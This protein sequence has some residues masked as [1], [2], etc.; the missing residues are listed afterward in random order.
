MNPRITAAD[1]RLHIDG[2]GPR[3]LLFLH[4]W[5]DTHRLWDG[6]VDA[7]RDRFRCARFT[8]PGF[9][10]GSAR[11]LPDL[12]DITALLLEVVDGLS[13]GEPVTLVLHDWGC[14]FGYQFALRHPQRV[15]RI[16][17]V[18]IG[19]T[20]NLARQLTGREKLGVLGYQLWLAA[21][22]RVGGGAGDWMTRRVARWAGA[23]APAS[24]LGWAMNWPYY[25]TWFGGPRA[26]PR[27]SRPF[28]PACPMLFLYGRRKPF[29][30]HTRGWADAVAARPGSR[31]EAFD[32]GHWVMAQAPQRFHQVV[33]DWL[34]DS[35]PAAGT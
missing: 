31:V 27:H 14:I 30:F 19:D 3:T 2:D 15:A 16:V 11:V 29:R 13:P 4:G 6:T 23:P 7:L 5:P 8:W 10:P 1:L 22:W 21:A 20:H 34:L 9:E 26:L 17:G 12:D 18:D 24:Q 35:P 33:R 28:E 25:L 32:T